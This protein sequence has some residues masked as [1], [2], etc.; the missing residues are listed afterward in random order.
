MKKLFSSRRFWILVIDTVVSLGTYFTVKYFAPGAA[1]DILT[2]MKYLQP[3]F[4]VIVI[5]YTADDAQRIYHANK[6]DRKG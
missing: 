1:D 3:L 4:V 6:Y 2:M 5:A